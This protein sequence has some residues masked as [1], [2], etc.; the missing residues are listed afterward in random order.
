[1]QTRDLVETTIDLSKSSKT[2]S[3]IEL[4]GRHKRALEKAKTSK[5]ILRLKRLENYKLR[6]LLGNQIL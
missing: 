3:W 6:I 4:I 5:E 2:C 1:M